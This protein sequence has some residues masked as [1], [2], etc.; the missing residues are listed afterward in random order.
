MNSPA[1]DFKTN[2]TCPYVPKR[3]SLFP[4]Q[5]TSAMQVHVTQSNSSDSGKVTIFVKPWEI[6][7]LRIKQSITSCTQTTTCSWLRSF[8]LR[9]IQD[10]LQTFS[11]SKHEQ[12]QLP[13][14]GNQIMV[15]VV[16]LTFK[17]QY[18]TIN[19]YRVP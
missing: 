11:S 14:V 15:W 4:S 5:S 9:T 16:T 12:K 13:G 17:L 8:V 3:I 6:T 19:L 18:S 7:F 1:L 2:L 10:F